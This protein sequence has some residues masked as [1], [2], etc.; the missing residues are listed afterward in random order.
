MGER[1]FYS[2]SCIGC[3]KENN[4]TR[5]KTPEARAKRKAYRLSNKDA[6][7]RRKD[8]WRSRNKEHVAAV[9]KAWYES[10]KTTASFKVKS[11][12]RDRV[13]Y[14]KKKDYFAQK[15]K[16]WIAANPD[17]WKALHGYHN[18]MRRKLLG[19]QK[20]AASF[21]QETRKFYES[22]PDGYHVDHIVPL[23]GKTVIGLHVP[24]NLQYLPAKDNMSKGNRRWPDMPE[25]A[26]G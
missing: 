17:K 20:L 18:I 3:E 22:C 6:C 7:K 4:A 16:C 26:H 5:E 23:K 25:V 13:T 19:A 21:S 8:D 1:K 11:K 9:N 12:E 10:V 24:W 14:A 2:Y 15:H